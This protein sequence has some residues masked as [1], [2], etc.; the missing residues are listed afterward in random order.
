LHSRNGKDFDYIFILAGQGGICARE[1]AQM[2]YR[3]RHLK[4]KTVYLAFDKIGDNKAY[5][6]IEQIAKDI[7]TNYRRGVRDYPGIRNLP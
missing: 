2:S 3:I 5:P 1:L 6:L 7:E 4:S